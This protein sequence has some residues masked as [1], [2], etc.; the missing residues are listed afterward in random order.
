MDIGCKCE[1]YR[2]KWKLHNLWCD[3]QLS[4]LGCRV[5]TLGPQ[6][7]ALFQW[8]RRHSLAE[9]SQSLGVG[10]FKTSHCF[11]T[12]LPS[13]CLKPWALSSHPCLHAFGLVPC[14]LT[15]MGSS[16]P[17]RQPNKLSSLNCLFYHCSRNV[18]NTHP[19]WIYFKFSRRSVELLKCLYSLK[20]L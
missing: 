16:P 5:W 1:A 15:T 8:F 2:F 20:D 6:L 9:A 12:L 11:C 4:L 13:R 18:T 7:V 14:F 17:D 19:K 10:W 3:N